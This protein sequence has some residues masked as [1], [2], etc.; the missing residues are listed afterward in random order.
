EQARFEHHVVARRSLTRGG[1]RWATRPVVL[2]ED[3][4]R[5]VDLARELDEPVERRD[6]R[7]EHGGPGLDLRDLREPA[8]Q[9]PD[10]LRLLPRGSEE[11][12]GFHAPKSTAGGCAGTS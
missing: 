2:G 6:P 8:R 7:V 5:E 11:D 4:R 12:A 9:G 10:E 3:E 1:I